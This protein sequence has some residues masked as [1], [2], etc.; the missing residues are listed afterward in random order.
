MFFQLFFKEFS[1][2]LYLLF[3]FLNKYSLSIFITIFIGNTAYDPNIVCAHAQCMFVYFTRTHS[4]IDSLSALRI[5]LFSIIFP[6][7]RIP[8]D[9]LWICLVHICAMCNRVRIF[10][11]N[12]NSN[13]KWCYKKT[14]FSSVCRT[15]VWM[16]WRMCECK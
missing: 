1:C 8:I 3:I 4:K 14:D 2:T 7:M 11:E 5:A 13:S 12:N 6:G 16:M 15:A 10:M 9:S